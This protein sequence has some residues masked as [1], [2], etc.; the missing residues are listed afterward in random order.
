MVSVR[1]LHQAA[2][3]GGKQLLGCF[4]LVAVH[5]PAGHLTDAILG[6]LEIL[7]ETDFL[8]CLCMI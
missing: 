6:P 3:D 4:V 5:L 1:D 2:P 7:E 8:P